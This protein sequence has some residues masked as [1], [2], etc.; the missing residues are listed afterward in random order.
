MILVAGATGNVG[1]ELV[2]R[3]AAD[4][5]PVRATT[6]T[7]EKSGL[8]S[9]VDVV[10]GDFD[11]PETLPAALDGIDRVFVV[12]PGYGPEGP[13]QERTLVAAARAAGVQHLV[14]LSTS[15]VTHGATD[16]L[17]SGHRHGEQVVQDSGLAWTILRPGT[18]RTRTC[19]TGV[20]GRSE[21]GRPLRTRRYRFGTG[22]FS[23]SVR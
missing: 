9:G 19:S 2:A 18:Q 17:S 13:V 4:G 8:P 6:R 11:K 3:L 10:A 5:V 16:P 20:D 22:G 21:R 14:K 1:S 23:G 7:P 12:P 15:G